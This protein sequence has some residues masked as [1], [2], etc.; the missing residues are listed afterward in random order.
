MRRKNKTSISFAVRFTYLSKSSVLGKSKGWKKAA[1]FFDKHIIHSPKQSLVIM[2]IWH[3]GNISSDSVL[4]LDFRPCFPCRYFAVILPENC[5]S[6]KILL[7]YALFI[8][9][10]VPFV[11]TI[12]VYYIQQ[13]IGYKCVRLIEKSN[14]CVCFSREC[15]NNSD[16]PQHAE[17]SVNIKARMKFK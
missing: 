14:R 15:K 10:T 11:A 12:F 9:L 2:S 13:S 17:A 5:T 16:E 8:F 6:G 7:R 1:T 4:S 3:L